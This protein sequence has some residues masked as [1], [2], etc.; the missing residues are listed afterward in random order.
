[1]TIDAGYKNRVARVYMAALFMQVMDATIINVALPTLADE[2]GVEVTAVD[3]TVLSFSLALAIMTASAGWLG[4]RFGLKPTF[5]AALAGF[6]VASALCGAAQT[7]DQ[8]VA[9]RALQGGFA[10]ALAPIGSA[11]IFGAFPL[12]ERAIAARKVVTVVVI[13]PALGPIVGGAILEVTSWRWIFY[14][15]VPIGIAATVM[16]VLWLRRDEARPGEP[17]DLGGF[18]LAAA[19]IGLLIFGVSRGTERGWT[20][21]VILLSLGV[22]TLLA[23]ALVVVELRHPNPLLPLR[24]L[25]DRLF[26]VAN[27]LTV[28]LYAGFLALI[29]LVPQF[30]QNEGGY[31]PL[32]AGVALLPQPIGIL[33][34]SQVV[35]RVFYDRFGPRRL[36]VFGCVLGVVS[37]MA[38]T[39]VAPDAS[40]AV[41]GAI[42]FVRGLGVGLVFVPLQTAAYANI[43]PRDLP[44][45]T[46]ILNTTRQFSPALGVAI[47]S[48]VLAAG[49]GGASTGAQRIDAYQQAMWASVV[50]F[51]LA[52]LVA[53]RIDD[54]QAEHTRR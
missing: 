51:A 44:R 12:E 3:W 13:A 9:F 19:S 47:A 35:G 24:L 8:L 5:V 37:G 18:F 43:G 14:V 22:G 25:Q 1:M 16:A 48:A 30:V 29:F 36:L 52:T 11:L 10:G 27:L 39:Q 46:A 26:G 41:F 40:L 15:N 4:D 23:V 31:S 42:L 21:P 20:S 32:Q 28:P 6:V 38:M 2:F 54:Q 34:M 49:L 45:A 53:T 50:L 17:F 7:L 33:I